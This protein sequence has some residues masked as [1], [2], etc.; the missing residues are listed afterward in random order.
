MKELS[1]LNIIDQLCERLPLKICNTLTS[2]YPRKENHDKW[3]NYSASVQFPNSISFCWITN[4]AM[5]KGQG[6]LKSS[7]GMEKPHTTWMIIH[8]LQYWS[9]LKDFNYFDRRTL[10]SAVVMESFSPLVLYWFSYCWWSG[11]GKLKIIWS[12]R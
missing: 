12:S 2:I 1:F 3:N 11:P 7:I 4:G 8:R 10:C 6:W 9:F 5:Y